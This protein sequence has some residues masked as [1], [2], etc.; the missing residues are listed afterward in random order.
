MDAYEVIGAFVDR[1]RVD[2]EALKAALATDDGRQYLLDLVSLREMIADEV[3]QT[4]LV[5]RD[6]SAARWLSMAAAIVV[7]LGAGYVMGQRHG[8]EVAVVTMPSPVV[9]ELVRPISAPSPTKV[10][11]LEPGVNWKNAGGD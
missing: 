1:E 5:R 11:R 9:I 2:P 6:Q 4:G 3:P 7:T 8:A 10:I